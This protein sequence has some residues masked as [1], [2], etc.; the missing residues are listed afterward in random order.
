[1]S[2]DAVRQASVVLEVVGIVLLL[3]LLIT[4]APKHSIVK[5]LTVATILRSVCA[6]IPSVTYQRYR[7]QFG[8]IMLHRN[9]SDFCIGF[10]IALRYLTVVKAAFTVSFT[11]PLLYLAIQHSRYTGFESSSNSAFYRRTIKFLC[12]GPFVWALPSVLVTFPTIAHDRESLKPMFYEATCTISNTPYQVVSLSL[13]IFALLIATIISITFV[14]IMWRHVRLP[15]LSRS[16]GMLDLTRILRF[17]A[18][19]GIIV[20]SAVLYTV[21]MASWARD[22]ISRYSPRPMNTLFTLSVLWEAVTPILMFLIFGA[23]Q[24]V[25]EVWASWYHYLRRGDHFQRSGSGKPPAEESYLVFA[26]PGSRSRWNVFRQSVAV[27]PKG[28]VIIDIKQESFSDHSPMDSFMASTLTREGTIE[29]VR[30]THHMP[31]TKIAQ[32]IYRVS[33]QIYAVP[34]FTESPGLQPPPSRSRTTGS[35][36]P[37]EDIPRGHPFAHVGPQSMMEARKRGSWEETKAFMRACRQL[38]DRRDLEGGRDGNT[39]QATHQQ[40]AAPRPST[41]GI[42]GGQ[43]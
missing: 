33:P 13:M 34:A 10:A 42:F 43:L 5:A 17:G 16:M 26:R 20:L 23:Q 14:Y 37:T 35:R 27:P 8:Y 38:V 15:M 3:A 9:L 39:S 4:P 25:F 11:S 40:D 29:E 1:M 6:I 28:G 2:W 32:D 12:F 31:I 7:E 24:E 36:N 41:S 22:H 19:F 18:L 30:P 21:V